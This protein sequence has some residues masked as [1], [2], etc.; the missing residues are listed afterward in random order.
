[1]W[2]GLIPLPE[3]SS[4]ISTRL[5][6][7][8]FDFIVKTLS[9]SVTELIASTAFIAAILVGLF[10]I[11]PRTNVAWRDVTVGALFTSIVFTLLKK[12]LAYYLAHLGSYAA[13]GV[14]GALL[15]FLTWIYLTSMLLYFGVELTRV[16]AERFGSLAGRA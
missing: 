13:Y 14:V 5:D 12:L 1:M 3:S 16:Y 15:G 11:L 6:S 9:R 10:R 2:L 7:Q 8:M 4:V